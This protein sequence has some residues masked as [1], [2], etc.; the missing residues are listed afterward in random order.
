MTLSHTAPPAMGWNSW[1]A[2]RAH[3]VTEEL[4]LRNADAL[5]D[6]G[7]ADAGYTT[8]VVDDG[9]QASNRDDR[10]RLRACPQR[11]PH[12]MG[13]L[14][15][16]LHERGL[17][18]GMYLSPGRRTCAQYWDHYGDRTPGRIERLLARA[19]LLAPQRAI[20]N[21]TQPP[22]SYDLGSYGR[23][24][25]DLNQLIEWEVDYLKYDWCRAE[26]GTTLES[27]PETFKAMS[28]LIEKAP[29]EI[30]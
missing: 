18:F 24:E 1:N 16:Q 2:Y 23:T 3:G 19:D 12:G 30:Y 25:A 29:R 6:L 13:W 26:R 11:F 4:V 28:E 15:K 17:R 7:L 21:A 14:G 5:I 22:A 9:W 20:D 10:G 27:R 8:V